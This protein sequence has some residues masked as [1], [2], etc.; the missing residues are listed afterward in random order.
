[1]K[2]SKV[3]HKKNMG[4]SGALGPFLKP[5]LQSHLCFKDLIWEILLPFYF[6]TTNIAKYRQLV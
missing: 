4:L 6:V 5:H 3:A 1:M 2:Q